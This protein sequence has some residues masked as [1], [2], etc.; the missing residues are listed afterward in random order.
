MVQLERVG[1]VLEAQPPESIAD[2]RT[3]R[4]QND[5]LLRHHEHRLSELLSALKEAPLT[6]RQAISVLFRREMDGH[7]MSFALGEAVAHLHYLWR[8]NL[9][10]RT[11]SNG[12]WKFQAV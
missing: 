6:A 7:Q 4:R 2:G 12:V 8:K 1:R 9:V 5:Q 11:Q 10:Q 3:D